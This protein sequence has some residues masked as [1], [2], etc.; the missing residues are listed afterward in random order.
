MSLPVLPIVVFYFLAFAAIT[1]WITF[2]NKPK[3]SGVIYSASIDDT[4]ELHGVLNYGVNHGEPLVAYA[5]VSDRELKKYP[6]RENLPVYSISSEER[7]LV[8]G[9]SRSGKTTYLITQLVNWMQSGKSFV[10]TDVKVEIWA[11]LHANGVLERY[12]YESIIINPTDP[13]A[14]KYNVFGDIDDASFA[15]E[16]IE[17]IEVLV[18]NVEFEI[19][20][21]ILL[22]AVLLHLKALGQSV[23]LLKVRDYLASYDD[24]DELLYDLKSSESALVRELIAEIKKISTNERYIGSCYGVIS[25]ALRFLDNETIAASTDTSDVFL[26]EVLKQPRTAIFLQFDQAY[27]EQTATLFG[28]TLAH[29]LR[30]LQMNFRNREEVF[31]AIDEI[32][33]SAPIPKLAQKLNTMGSAKMPLFMYLQALKGLDNVY[34]EGSSELFMSACTLKICYRVNE[35]NTGQQFSDLIGNVDVERWSVAETPQISNE[36]RNYMQRS[37]SSTADR[38]PF[39]EPSKLSDLKIGHAVVIYRG[40]AARVVMSHYEDI[41]PM[42]MIAKYGTLSELAEFD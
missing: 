36:G 12:G 26:R 28:F 34:G 17:L 11:I 38:L 5:P 30:L 37:V 24:T 33:N 19:G 15:T 8:L 2:F 40:K 35:N 6:W 29:I 14:D 41:Y 31:V 10:V 7:G 27:V 13:L 20:A 21:K 9:V 42:D 25:K 1:L 4:S 22:R 3:K 23:S 16:T 32:I 18:G 39:I